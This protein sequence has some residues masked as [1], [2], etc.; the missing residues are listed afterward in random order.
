[1]PEKKVAISRARRW[2]AGR[3]G[4]K[5][6][7]PEVGRPRAITPEIAQVI[8]ERIA[9]GRTLLDVARDEDLPHR[10]TIYQAMRGDGV[11]AAA[12]AAARAESAFSLA[13]E[14]ILIADEAKDPAMSQLVHNCCDQRR[15]L[16]GKFNALFSDKTAITDADG[17]SLV[18]RFRRMNA[19]EREAALMTLAVKVSRRSRGRARA[20]VL[21][22]A[23]GDRFHRPRMCRRAGS[24][25]AFPARSGRYLK[26]CA[27]PIWRCRGN[28]TSRDSATTKL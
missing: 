19:E 5:D 2:P 24:L 28:R 15:W 13:E 25:S 27:S 6:R 17:G 9:R 12:I 16:A 22:W 7:G 1:M 18:E 23:A 3:Q 11:F 14:T 10:D 26:N 21:Y 8:C 20:R 4:A